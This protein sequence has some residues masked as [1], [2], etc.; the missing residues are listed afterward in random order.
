MDTLSPEA[1]APSAPDDVISGDF[2]DDLPGG[3]SR[4]R[5]LGP[6]VWLSSH[7]AFLL[8]RHEDVQRALRDNNIREV[9][10]GHHWREVGSRLGRDYA[11]VLTLLSYMPFHHRGE[12]HAWQRR[13]LAVALAPF[14]S[15]SDLIDRRVDALTAGL[16]DV[17]RFDFVPEFADRLFF[18]VM[19]DVI[20]AREDHRRAL[21]PV[22]GMSYGLDSLLPVRL[23]DLFAERFREGYRALLDLA[24]MDGRRRDNAFLSALRDALPEAFRTD[25]AVAMY[26]A[27]SM[28]M[29]NDATGACLSFAL[30][31]LLDPDLDLGI[32]QT[33]W[34]SYADEAL[35]VISPIHVFVRRVHADC[36]IAG[37]PLYGGERLL[38][39]IYSANTDRGSFG[40]R[41]DVIGGA[42]DAGLALA[43]GAGMHVCVGNRFARAIVRSALASLSDL[44]ALR[45]AGPPELG[46]ASFIRRMS[47]L[48]LGFA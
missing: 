33:D 38:M 16:R 11:L 47:S 5:E 18:E 23:R 21:R 45:L 34:Q 28:L 1:R 9:D 3:Y 4:L 46:R 13:C 7:K 6:V 22:S 41:A 30:R 17:E 37:V 36:E 29:G 12:E 10:G 39:S 32:P 43:F 40:A 31:D 24:E 20:G 48:P 14:A 42:P 19:C 15:G 26:V 27:I 25:E 35:R 44:P 2:M 8:T